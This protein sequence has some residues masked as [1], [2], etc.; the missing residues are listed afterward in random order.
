MYMGMQYSTLTLYFQH[1]K[2]GREG[3]KLKKGQFEWDGGRIKFES[4]LKSGGTKMGTENP[5]VNNAN[6]E[7]IDDTK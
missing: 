3:L 4:N 5:S 6:A 1:K 7:R 2:G